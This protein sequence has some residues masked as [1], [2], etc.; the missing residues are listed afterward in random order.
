MFPFRSLL[1]IFLFFYRIVS[2]VD[3]IPSLS[4]LSFSL[5]EENL[6]RRTLLGMALILQIANYSGSLIAG[7]NTHM[8]A[9]RTPSLFFSIVSYGRFMCCVSGRFS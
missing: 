1:L 2:I 9:K 3:Y 6:P 7:Q 4:F 8:T 5:P